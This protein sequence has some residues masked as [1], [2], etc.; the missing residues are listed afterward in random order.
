MDS[1]RKLAAE[2]PFDFEA[3]AITRI[4]GMAPNDV[5]VGVGGIDGRGTML[6][7]ALNL[8]SKRVLAQVKGGRFSLSQFRDFLHTVDREDAALGVYITLENVNSPNARAE[9]QGMGKVRVGASEFPRVQLWSIHDYFD[10][11]SP[12]LPAMADDYTGKPMQPQLM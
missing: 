12:L 1:A 5:N 10:D 4:P 8:V 9:A 7:A 3:W 2:N 6:D 11:R